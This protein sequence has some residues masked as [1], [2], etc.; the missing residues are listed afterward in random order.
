MRFALLLSVCG[1]LC[2]GSVDARPVDG[3]AGAAGA[4]QSTGGA[5]AEGGKTGTGGVFVTAG[6]AGTGGQLGTGGA[7][8]ASTGADG[9]PGAAAAPACA[10]S[11]A[12]ATPCQVQIS[13]QPGGWECATSCRGTDGGAVD[14]VFNGV[15]YCVASCGDCR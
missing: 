14:C 3:A 8:G 5:P 9:G 13:G 12:A 1:L 10:G 15:T 2:C 6:A 7:A 11:F 4:P